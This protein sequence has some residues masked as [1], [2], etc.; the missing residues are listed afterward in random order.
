MKT[1]IKGLLTLFFALLMQVTFAQEKVVS[2]VVKDN[3]GV[4]LSGVNVIV[5][6]T[7]SSTQT[8]LD[9]KYTIKASE[10][11]TIEF[12]FIGTKT[13]TITVG[14]GNSYNVV[15]ENSSEVME[16]VVVIGYGTQKKKEV[17]SS[18]SK[19]KGSDIQGLVTPSFESQLAGRAAGVQVT[20][21]TGIVGAAPRVRIRGI[22]SINSG[23][24]PLYVVDGIPMYSVDLGGYADANALGDI[25]PA[26]IESFEVLKDGA[27]S[28]IYGSRAAN[29]V[30]LITTKKGKKGVMKVDYNVVS[31]F[32]S[33]FKTFDL[34]QTPDFLTISN[35]KRTNAGQPAWAVGSDFNTDWQAAVLRKSAFQ[36][37][38][39]LSFNGGNDKTKYYM[40]MGYA[41]QEGIAVSNEMRRY[42]FRSSLDHQV[43]K[44]LTIGGNVGLTRTEYEGL[45]TGRNSLSGNMFNAI[46]QLP[47]TPIY[48]P[49]N[50]TGYNINL[51]TGNVGQG[52]NLQ[53]VG[54]NISNI[55]YVLDFNKFESNINRTII[56]AFASA[57][58]LKGL[59]YRFQASADNANTGGF[60]YWNPIHGDGRGSNGRLQNSSTDLMRW[61]TQN[62]LN[63]NRT[64]LSAHNVSATGVV[65]YQKERNQNFFGIGTNL[66]N[67][68][69]NQNL[70]TGS[71]GT[72]ESGGGITEIGIISYIGR[73][74]YNYKQKYFLQGSL[75]RDGISRLDPETRWNTFTG[76][77]A[78]WNI[79]KE[80]F[81]SGINKYVSDFKLRAS[82]AEVGNTEIGTYPYLGLTSASQYGA[83]N[84]IAFTQFGNDILQ[85]E[86]SKKTDYGVDLALLNNKI[87]ITFDY[88]KNDIDGLILD[89]P[90]PPSL[91]V[92]SNS[93]RKNIGE[94]VNDGYEFGIDVSLINNDNFKWDVN[95]NLTLQSNEVTSTP[96]GADIIGGS[97]TDVNISPNIIIRQGESINSLYGFE[98]WGVNPSN[99]FP[100][101]YKADGS[102]VQGNPASQTYSVF[103]PNNPSNTST[104]ATLTLADKRILGNTIPTYY[105]GFSSR[106]SYKNVDLSFLIRF[107]GGNK[108]FNSTRREL[109]NQNLNNNGDEILGRW[110]SASNPGD[111]WTPLL[112]ANSNTFLNQSSNATSR[113][114]ENGDF[115][116]F[117]NLTLGYNLSRKVAEKIQVE[118]IRFF[119]QGQNLFMITDYK[120]LDPEMET[121]GVDLN[122]TPRGR[123][124][125]MGINVKL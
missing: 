92:P 4:I 66:L 32:A 111:G 85:W 71:Y 69:Y 120:G 37:D 74:S 68:F 61:N 89:A 31:G 6:E 51:S 81:M 7:K 44:W 1:K 40:S 49:A 53:P 54:D 78:G 101:Y 36:M 113:F 97:S 96:N 124:F 114:V 115:I 88:F 79:A 95:T 87:R 26:D 67:E 16:E 109:M 90:V 27:A 118:G 123:I 24:Q 73:L 125:S 107:S 48:D 22:A 25:N 42:T 28:A 38:H 20:T 86:T 103:D 8:D 84:G 29:G 64:F 119:V 57:K 76:Y 33:P 18:V 98:Y 43:T 121:S 82:Y 80:S 19:I 100:V 50:P 63:Y 94:M 52:T 34:L 112:Y 9:G 41:T 5:K 55:V 46:R 105:G 104:S 11:N 72:Q 35:E 30:I 60:L 12:S 77:S 70:V 2:G 10:G 99:G 23:T 3:N 39:N 93:I 91:G 65:E 21:P 102:L 15:L 117:D 106:M 13:K 14:K 75:R 110:Q 45:N 122:G 58:I 17:T 59:D 83:L 62:I 47:N 108:I 116:S 56:S